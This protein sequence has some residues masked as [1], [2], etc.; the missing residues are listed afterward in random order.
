MGYKNESK[1]YED[2]L[3]LLERGKVSTEYAVGKMIKQKQMND[4]K[5]NPNQEDVNA[6]MVELDTLIGLERVKKLAREIQAYILIQN[7]RREEHLAADSL[8]LHMIFK[9][10]P[11]TGK[12]TVARL[13]GKILCAMG[14][15]EKGHVVEVER[16]DLV[17]GY[18]GHTAAK[19]REQIKESL[20]GI[21]F[22][23]EAYSLAR[24]G[25][26]D[27]GKEAIDA[28]VK[29][30]E[31]YKDNLILI[32]AG[33]KEEM[34][35]FLK[36]N[37]GLKS[38]F[39]IHIEFTDYTLDELIKIAEDMVKKRQYILSLSAKAKILRILSQKR[40]EDRITSGN[41]R[42]VRNIIERAIRKQAIRLKDSGSFSREDLITLKRDDITEEDH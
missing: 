5:R 41:A 3:N 21:M 18:I 25:E 34:E 38:R 26:K 24:G 28:M 1:V 31:D 27:F 7:K 29:G 12:T 30:M 9:G 35:N 23:D 6:M 19:V 33:Y 22:I 14:V 37:P 11:G 15:L 32:L 36:T 39:P 40:I 10:N 42:L 2:I 20:G 16:A 17:G 13:L 8:V 4:N